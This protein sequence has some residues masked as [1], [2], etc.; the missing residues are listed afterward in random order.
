MNSVGLEQ[1]RN[2]YPIDV[3]IATA[4]QPTADQFKTIKQAKFDLII[5]LALADSPNAITDEGELIR[6]LEMD[7]IHI[8]VDFKAPTLDDLNTFFAVIDQHQDKRIFV[9]C[10]LNWRVSAFI[11][12][13][14]R[15]RQ[16]V[17]A[18]DAFSAMKAVWKP[19]N[20]WQQFIESA[21]AHY[22]IQD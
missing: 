16:H 8:P 20:T 15:I 19:D 4:G 2:Y 22:Q 18:S 12:L 5:N 6:Q 21:L 11:F 17:P 7:Y 3:H 1:I 13:Y 10:A 14:K 9:H